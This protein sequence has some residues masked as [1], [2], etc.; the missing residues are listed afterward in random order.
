MEVMTVFQHRI[1]AFAMVVAFGVDV[2]VVAA[3]SIKAFMTMDKSD[4]GVP[5]Q[6]VH[7]PTL[8]AGAY[9]SLI[10]I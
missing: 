1:D 2:V 7:L 5:P 4:V 6:A 8:A 9:L 3:A 10:H